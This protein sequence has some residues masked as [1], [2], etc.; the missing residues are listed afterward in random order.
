MR[1]NDMIVT[2]E[3]ISKMIVLTFASDREKN[4]NDEKDGIRYETRHYSVEP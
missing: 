1:E 2:N 4:Y 3:F